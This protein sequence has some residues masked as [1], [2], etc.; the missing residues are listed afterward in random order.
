MCG[1]LAFGI[2]LLLTK[3]LEPDKTKTIQSASYLGFFLKGFIINTANPTP[4]FFWSALMWTAVDNQYTNAITSLLFGS[5]IFVVI[6]SD[7]L[8]IYLAKYIRRK[9]TTDKLGYIRR[10]A[11]IALIGFAIFLAV[12][13]YLSQ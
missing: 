6:T 3:P 1:L 10:I 5:V 9:L 4:L 7:I 13:V 11:G 12:R 8:K 2:I